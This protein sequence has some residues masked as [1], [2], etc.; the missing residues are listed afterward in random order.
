METLVARLGE[1]APYAY[2]FKNDAQIGGSPPDPIASITGVVLTALTPTSAPLPVLGNPA[3]SGTQ[4]V[5]KITM[6]TQ[7]ARYQVAVTV[8][9]TAGYIR[10]GMGILA[11]EDD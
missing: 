8:V 2:D 5:F 6:P 4:V 11:V 9:T 3:I 7:E 1:T 10:V